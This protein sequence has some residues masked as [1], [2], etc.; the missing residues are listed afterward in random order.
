MT[1]DQ[2]SKTA[3]GRPVNWVPALAHS[4]RQGCWLAIDVA[5]RNSLR[6]GT[7]HVCRRRAR[8]SVA[9]IPSPVTLR[10]PLVAIISAGYGPACDQGQGGLC[11]RREWQAKKLAPAL[12][13]NDSFD[14][15]AGPRHRQTF[16]GEEIFEFS[17]SLFPV[18]P[19]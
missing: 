11:R 8:G 1:N 3:S 9:P 6:R 7:F 15:N 4:H 18:F 13:A 2:P 5:L 17:D 19:E 12:G 14:H 10:A 16:A